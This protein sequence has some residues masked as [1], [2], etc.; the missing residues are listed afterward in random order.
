MPSGCPSEEDVACFVEGRADAS[1]S[2]RILA[3]LDRCNAC[4]VLLANSLGA[5]PADAV[6]DRVPRTFHVGSV[7]GAR[8]RIDRFIAQG[9]MGE[10]YA[11]WDLELDE[12]VALKTLACTRLDHTGLAGRIRAEVQMARRVSHPNVCRILEFG[13]HR[14]SYRG[15]EEAIP[16][17]TMDFLV[18]ETLAARVA[19]R[20]LTELEAAAIGSEVLD[21]LAAI[22]A[23]GIV[24]RD[25][26]PEN[27]FLVSNVTGESRAVVMD[28]GLARLTDVQASLVSSAGSA[29]LGTPAYM[30]PE[31]ALGGTPST[32][33]DIYA[34]GVVLFR[35]MAGQLPFQ[36]NTS[37]A[38][39]VARLRQPAPRLS[40]VVP[41]VN[42][43][44]EAVVAR[45][46]E[47][48]PLRRFSSATD[49]RRALSAA[50]RP[51]R[52]R[53][54]RPLLHNLFRVVLLGVG[55]ATLLGNRGG[56]AGAA[57]RSQADEP[58]LAQPAPVGPERTAD[59]PAAACLPVPSATAAGVR[60]QARPHRRTA[61][62]LPVAPGASA[63]SAPKGARAPQ[64]AEDDD[65]V[66]PAFAGKAPA[67]DE[68]GS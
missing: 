56:E 54:V 25:L 59:P 32:A 28:F 4:R 68:Q 26:K 33:W 6:A 45:C 55:L 12:A 64:P 52:R 35:L 23:A 42:P 24:H 49:L 14:Q 34:F 66:I 17:F 30:A 58:P 21:G 18:G 63:T 39:T 60:N 27:V 11:A 2:R 44:M 41:G 7:V 19:R 47:R 16:F 5:S 46:L 50:H 3:H 61:R 38:L 20:R 29:P 53:R 10:V 67:T 36:G 62:A 1:I 65:V 48:D 57:A 8:Y 37:A 43:A 9:G 51:T 31:Q 22:H 40:S 13:L 15:Q